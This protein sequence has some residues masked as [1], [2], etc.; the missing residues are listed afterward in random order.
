MRIPRR[1]AA[2]LAST[3]LL[4][5]VL[6][7]PAGAVHY[8]YTANDDAFGTTSGFTIGSGSSL[9]PIPDATEDADAFPDSAVISPDGKH[10]YVGSFKLQAYDIA[11]DGSLTPMAGSPFGNQ[12]FHQLA[13]TPD[14]SRLYAGGGT[15]NTIVGFA[16]AADGTPSALPGS[17]YAIGGTFAFGVALTP[18]GQHLYAS[19][20]TSNNLWGFNVNADGSLAPAPGSPIST[21]AGAT[22]PQFIGVAPGGRFLYVANNGTTSVAAF[23]VNNDGSLSTLVGSPFAAGSGPWGATVS[24]DGKHLYVGNQLSGSVSGYAINQISGQLV[25][26]GAPFA[27]GAGTRTIAVTADGSSVFSAN[28]TG[29]NVSRY[30]RN[31]GTGVLTAVPPPQAAGNGATGAAITPN[32]PPN[33]A[34]GPTISNSHDV[35]FTSTTTDPDSAGPIADYSWDFGDGATATGPDT[36]QT[37]TYAADGTYDVRLTATDS[38]GCGPTPVYNGQ[39]LYCN[40]GGPATLVQPVTVDTVLSGAKFKAKKT[41]KQKPKKGKVVIKAKAGAAEKVLLTVS[42]GKVKVP[43]AGKVKL[44]KV[45]QADVAAGKLKKLKLK[46]AGKKGT[47]QILAAIGAGKKVKA[48]FTV[49]LADDAGN[50]AEKKLKV[51]LK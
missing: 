28:L 25:S 11:A 40:G 50:F 32:Q 13:I 10:L 9:T 29:D 33:A 45:P 35:T 12:S 44:K 6:A 3:A 26:L 36:T 37:H 30:A 17:P 46:P 34:F 39:M 22:K 1:I 5:L 14:G 38:E 21:G 23:F 16:L 24:P 7:T 42:S 19:G 4:V 8:L 27:A 48:S 31:S 18:D 43:G 15:S 20:T 47:K 51:T 41:Q 2:V 49:R